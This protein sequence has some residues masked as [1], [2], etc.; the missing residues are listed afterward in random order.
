MLFLTNINNS[1]LYCQ[2]K[3]D[4]SPALKNKR[5]NNASCS[6]SP[7]ICHPEKS[8]RRKFWAALHSSCLGPLAVFLDV[9]Q[10]YM[11]RP[12]SSHHRSGCVPSLA[13]HREAAVLHSVG[14]SHLLW[15]W[16][17]NRKPF[18]FPKISKCLHWCAETLAWHLRDWPLTI[19]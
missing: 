13:M 9:R 1:V 6:R 3:N 7:N 16:C 10:I 17:W 2:K 11:Y 8:L 4:V 19:R 12:L 18:S 5:L 15:K 14:Q